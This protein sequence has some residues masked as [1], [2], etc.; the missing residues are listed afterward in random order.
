VALLLKTKPFATTTSAWQ[1]GRF[2]RK[3]AI[4]PAAMDLDFFRKCRL[5]KEKRKKRCTI[6]SQVP[7]TVMTAL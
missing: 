5:E 1:K 4:G 6:E 3:G 7:S 2:I